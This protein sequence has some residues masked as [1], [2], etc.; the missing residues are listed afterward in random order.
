MS[1]GGGDGGGDGD[2]DGARKNLPSPHPTRPGKNIPVRDSPHSDMV[3]AGG[4]SPSPVGMVVG[5]ACVVER[6]VVRRHEKML[7]YVWAL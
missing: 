7:R 4:Y 5:W 3:K 6:A 1:P 2:G